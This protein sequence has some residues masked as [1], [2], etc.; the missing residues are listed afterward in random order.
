LFKSFYT[1]LILLYF[2]VCWITNY[3]AFNTKSFIMKNSN[4]ILLAIL[5][6][7]LVSSCMGPMSK[8][9]KQKMTQVHVPAANVLAGAYH[10]PAVMSNNTAGAIGFASGLT[11]GLIGGVIA[12]VVVAGVDANHARR[13]KDTFSMIEANTPKDLGTMTAQKLNA[14]LKLDPF[15]GPR[16]SMN[17]QVISQISVSINGYTLQKTGTY[18]S[19]AISALVTLQLEGKKVRQFIQAANGYDGGAPLASVKRTVYSASKEAYAADA[20]LMR[21][22]YECVVGYL[23]EDI[24]TKLN[25]FAG[26]EGKAAT[27]TAAASTAVTTL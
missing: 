9:Q 6:P 15:Y 25:S 23:V 1:A 17:P 8:A 3:Q 14:R 2:L 24:A 19:P 12:T 22:H 20:N 21:Q 10:R 5:I 7:S 18:Y 11:G 16:L 27:S 26:A 4:S 13:N